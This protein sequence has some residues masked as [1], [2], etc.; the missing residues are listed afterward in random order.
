MPEASVVEN[1]DKDYKFGF[2]DKEDYVFKSEKGLNRDIVER[3]SARKEEPE[4][5]LWACQISPR[6]MGQAHDRSA[7]VKRHRYI[8]RQHN[9]VLSNSKRHHTFC[10][11]NRWLR[12]CQCGLTLVT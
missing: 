10:F 1:L 9:R 6:A 2:H 7:F 12:I 3:I 5:M 8:V 11:S 4:W